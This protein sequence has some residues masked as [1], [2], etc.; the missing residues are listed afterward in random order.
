MRPPKVDALVLPK[1]EDP[2]VRPP[3]PCT[4]VFGLCAA[5]TDGKAQAAINP[6]RMNS[7]RI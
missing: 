6:A 7:L 4:S 5:A 1:L 3:N 2:K